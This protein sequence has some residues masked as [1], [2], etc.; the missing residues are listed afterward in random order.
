MDIELRKS[1]TA[2]NRIY[3]IWLFGG[4]FLSIVFGLQV[5]LGKYEDQILDACL[6][7]FPLIFPILIVTKIRGVQIHKSKLQIKDSMNLMLLTIIYWGSLLYFI[8]IFGVIFYLAFT[9]LPTIS[10]LKNSNYLLYPLQ[11]VLDAVMVLF[12]NHYQT[13][14]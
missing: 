3:I 7:F 5:L 13:N 6:W 14:N 12:I 11:F 2:F 10:Y 1:E 8:S 4:S 9:W